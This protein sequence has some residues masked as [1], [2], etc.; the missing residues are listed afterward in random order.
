[1]R[2]PSPP[3]RLSYADAVKLLGAGE[4][5]TMALFDRVSGL[6]AAGVTVA[7]AGTVD[8]FALRDEL[9]RWGNQTLRGIGE[10]LT[11][12]SR[13]DRTQ[14]LLAAHS[15]L[16]VT[17][18]FD[19]FDEV[20]REDGRLDPAAAEITAAEQVT[21]A[22]GNWPGDRYE[23]LITT[24]LHESPPLPSPSQPYEH[25]LIRLDS[26]FAALTFRVRDFLHG[27]ASFE[28]SQLDASALDDE[29]TN[30]VVE[31]AIERY[32]VNYRQLAAEVP[33][34]A[35][36]VGLIDAQATRSAVDR[37][38]VTL[39]E[40]IAELHTGLAGIEELLTRVVVDATPDARRADLAKRYRA[41]LHQPILNP[42]DLPEHVTL[43]T[44]V[45]AYVNPRC[46]IATVG[47]ADQPATERWWSEQRILT[48]VQAF[49]A[50]HL[51]GPDAVDAPLVVL[52]QPGSGKSVFT[53]V[54]AARLPETDFF[55]VRVELRSVA[56]DAT[57]QD[58]IEEAFHLTTGERVGWPDL[59]RAALGALPVVMLDGFD[60]MLQATGLNRADYL[61]RVQ[62]FQQR[63]AELARPV[64][65]IVTSRTV[66]ADRARFPD[67][68]LA[69]LLEPFDEEQVAEWLATWNGLNEAGLRRRG[70]NP[71]PLSVAMSHAELATQP[72]LL[73]LLAL[74][75]LS[76][77]ALQTGGDDLGR[78]DL[79]ER[80][81]V[82]FAGREVD[83]H[84]SELT[85]AR[86][87]DA[88]ES[89]LRRLSA[90]AAALFNRRGDVI[91]EADLDRD[92]PHLLG[93]DDLAR[94][95]GDGSAS[96]SLTP[97]QLLVGRFF[98]IHESQAN[99]DTGAPEKVFEFLHATFGEFLAARLVVSTLVDLAEERL[100]QRRRPQAR[101]LDAGYLYALTSFG[102][103]TRRGPIREFCAGL[104]ARLDD[105]RRRA[106]RELLSDLLADA[107]FPHPT[108][109]LADYEPIRLP[110]AARHAAYSANLVTLYVLLHQDPVDVAELL[111]TEETEDAW[112]RYASLWR[113]QLPL[114]DWRTLWQ[115][116]RVEWRASG[117]GSDRRLTV[118]VE[119]DSPLSLYASLPWPSVGR[120]PGDDHDEDDERN[121]ELFP[122]FV[123]AEHDWVADELR[124]LGFLQTP[125][126]FRVF[127]HGQVPLLRLPQSLEWY[128][129]YGTNGTPNTRLLLELLL[130]EPSVE[131]F[132]RRVACYQHLVGE[133]DF[134]LGVQ[135]LVVQLLR[136]DARELPVAGMAR[137]LASAKP[138]R[139]ELD[140][141][142]DL[143]ATVAA[144]TTDAEL[145]RRLVEQLPESEDECYQE[146][147]NELRREAYRRLGLDEA[148]APG[149]VP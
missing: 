38:G 120:F 14:R 104:L 145:M 41:R 127:L 119:D 42:R 40:R 73:L 134:A 35:V 6:A 81:F 91:T 118:R 79:Y 28:P 2:L 137:I 36:W 52:G 138:A 98:F 15:V 103:L 131:N 82:D 4:S 62:E 57:I 20:L 58:Q 146:R 75:D 30:Q 102:A 77:N 24:L 78:V 80:L 147:I 9:S 21:L 70:L 32:V 87:R 116:L 106:C 95:P 11:G 114:D 111:R 34:F 49:L 115:A 63:E 101:V 132:E 85:D 113:S 48:D 83:K 47:R 27:L 60:E 18:F 84:D 108:W 88:V 96:R 143:V 129:P 122:D 99:R 22:T 90:V 66:V 93:P 117:L 29:A 123:K 144:R 61:Y 141:M 121:N 124:E 148:D 149:D 140:T 26:Y 10:R 12:I 16:V 135:E 94:S 92:L 67:G 3:K 97:G 112:H 1:M 8:F 56:A 19:A 64:A 65:V 130:D 59:S 37:V 107:G 125:H 13:F 54:L 126:E 89:E 71:L 23:A 72:L 33:E 53:R 100:H 44:L 51:T 69:I 39:Q 25:T 86:R 110:V 139:I 45:A 105:D 50:G 76:A 46:R 55:P 17:A 109:S 128:V 68:S 31:H 74:Y 43:P 136:R 7:S 133:T 142:I 5:R